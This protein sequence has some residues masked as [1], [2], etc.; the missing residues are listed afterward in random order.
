[1]PRASVGGAAF[2]PAAEQAARAEMLAKGVERGVISQAEAELFDE[3][4]AAMDERAAVGETPRSGG[5]DQMRDVLLAE[6][7]EQGTITQEQ[8]DVFNEVHERLVEAGLME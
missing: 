8:S 4:H 3:V 1:M 2:D 5:M 7:V 6:L